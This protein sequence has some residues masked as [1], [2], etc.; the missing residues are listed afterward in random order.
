MRDRA[1]PAHDRHPVARRHD[2]AQFV[3]DEDD[4]P[5]A[6]AQRAEDAEQVVR[7]ARGQHAGGFVEDENVRAAV[8]RLEDLHPLP[9]PHR[10]RAD[11]RVRVRLQPV[12][13]PQPFERAPRPRQRPPQ[14]EAALDAQD[15]V[16]QHGETVHQHEMLVDHADS[17][18]D[19]VV[20]AGD[21]R[22][23]SADPD[24]AAVGPVVAVDDVH[25]GGFAGAVL[26][27][28]AVDRPPRDGHRDADVGAPRAEPLVDSDGLE[29][30]RRALR[31][32]RRHGAIARCNRSRRWRRRRCRAAPARSR[33]PFRR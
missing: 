13:A 2:L 17:E 5:A 31:P 22:A 3:G 28:D 12:F 6:V 32:P 16:L 30:G 9:H 7:L 20:R 10:E 18:R 19:G 15:D 25:Q 14:E 4:R 27:D 21:P 33:P 1:A 24:L 11:D 29:G 26:A 23:P 8:E